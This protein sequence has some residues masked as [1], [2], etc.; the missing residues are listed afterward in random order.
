MHAH[1]P[2]GSRADAINFGRTLTRHIIEPS[3]TPTPALPTFTSPPQ[4]K[5]PKQALDNP[6]RR[7]FGPYLRVGVCVAGGSVGLY[8]T[9]DS[10]K[11]EARVEEAMQKLT[12]ENFVLASLTP[13]SRSCSMT[14]SGE[15]VQ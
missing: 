8:D 12:E 9:L 15:R 11:A 6:Q 13:C 10:C 1:L 7:F 3:T 2:I 14:V 5:R 4:K